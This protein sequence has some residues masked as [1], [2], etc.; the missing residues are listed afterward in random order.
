MATTTATPITPFSPVPTNV[1]SNK[2]YTAIKI[3]PCSA[4][5]CE[6]FASFTMDGL[7]SKVI[8]D[9]NTIPHVTQDDIEIV[10]K[11]LMAHENVSQ[12]DLSFNY[13]YYDFKMFTE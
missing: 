11:K 1:A 2:I 4:E 9:L 12:D 3:D 8:A 6:V 10:R 13:W 5:S 7:I